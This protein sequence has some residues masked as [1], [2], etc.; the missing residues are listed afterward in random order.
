M[1]DRF[2]PEQRHRCMSHIKSKNTSLEV[3]VRKE[4]FKRGYR[5]RIN[6]KNLAGHP[7]IVLKKYKT[8]IFINGCFWHG[9]ENCKK[10]TI[11]QTNT[12]F[13]REKIQRNKE[14]D[15]ETI[16]ILQNSGWNV[17]V[18]WECELAKKRF[19]DTIES[20]VTK[21]KSNLKDRDCI[22]IGYY[23]MDKIDTK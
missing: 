20:V 1:A 18:V 4:L 8:A 22:K 19:N 2:T 11:P 12:E 7:D 10:A 13:W 15:E 9:H 6:V 21:I 5:Y 23:S 3:L 14:R 17:I 16:A